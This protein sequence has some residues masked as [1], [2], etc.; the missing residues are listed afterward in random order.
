M[1]VSL[2]SHV[3][4]N[5]GGFAVTNSVFTAFF[6]TFILMVFTLVSSRSFALIPTRVQLGLELL[7][8]FMTEQLRSSFGS[9][10]KA[11][12]FFPLVMSLLLFIVVANQFTI[13]PL[14]SNLLLNDTH[15]FRLPT[16][17]LSLTMAFSFLVLL[18]ANGLALSISPLQH[19]GKFFR[20]S[21]LISVRSFGDI[22]NALLEVFLGL[23]DIIGE[24]GKLLSLSFR[25]FGNIF[26]GELMVGIIAGLSIYTSFIV[27]IPFIVLSMFSGLIQAFVFVFLTIQFIA[28][29][30]GDA[31]AAREA[32]S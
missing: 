11:R 20:L 32:R 19:V 24:F 28:G 10:E 29:S 12:R 25:L 4:F 21:P 1:D 22:P 13:V 23:L 14:V 9:E 27:P 6:L 7:A 8:E 5:L 18:L 2:P 16:S 30:V 31:E 26:A 3:L 15:V 17:D